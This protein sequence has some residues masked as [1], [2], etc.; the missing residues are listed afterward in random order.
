[1]KNCSVKGKEKDKLK[2]NDQFI[3]F[4]GEKIIPHLLL[5]N[6]NLHIDILIDPL[7]E[8]GKNTKHLSRM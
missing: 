3:G 8:V 2:N 5:K 1:M 7:N 6:N 4:N